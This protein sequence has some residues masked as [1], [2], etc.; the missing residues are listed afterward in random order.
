M[1]V[2]LPKPHAIG[3]ALLCLAAAASTGAAHSLEEL[4]SQLGERERYFQ[5]FDK[6]APAFELRDA[7]G[8]TVRLSDS[9]GK[10]VVL[11]FIYASCPDVCPLHS[12]RIAEIQEMIALTPMQG[13]VQFV[14]VTTD[15]DRDTPEVLRGYGLAHG[16]DPANW[17]FLTSGPGRPAATRRLAE[18]YGHKFT[19]AEGGYQVHGVVTHVIDGEGRW[20]ANF[21]GLKFDPANLVVFVNA[22]VND[23][24]RPHPHDG[25]GFWQKLRELF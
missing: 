6:K 14:S 9:R 23:A 19:L 25:P 13:Q 16:L 3:L 17:L 5:P 1:T 7:D 10:V 2:P 15:P 20:R 12:R 11:N 21:H 24:H 22:L 4:E 8:R 18:R